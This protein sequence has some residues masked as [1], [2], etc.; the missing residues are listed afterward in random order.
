MMNMWKSSLIVLGIFLF[1]GC[2]TSTLATQTLMT[3]SIILE[4]KKAVSVYITYKNTA[5]SHIELQPVLEDALTKKG[6]HISDDYEK[7]TY[8]L[9]VNIL[10]ATNIKQALA[11]QNAT[12]A[13]VSGALVGTA[14]KSSLKE[15]AIVGAAAA[16][17]ATVV[18][19]ALEDEIY[20]AVVDIQVDGDAKT[21]KT[22]VFAEARQMNLDKSVALP[23]LSQIVAS[24]I[25]EIF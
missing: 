4:P 22:R 16:L 24:Q 23:R 1:A 18:S 11:V 9:F 25:A 8:K 13:G 5:L 19:K 21:Q 12:V 3:R 17:G 15:G 6:I 14:V 2:G 20:K 7:A 10:F